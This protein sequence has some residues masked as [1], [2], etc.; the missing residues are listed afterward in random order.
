MSRAVI[1]VVSSNLP[2]HNQG[3][4]HHDISGPIYAMHHAI[5]IEELYSALIARFN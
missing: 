5:L 1:S 4:S 3:L 2:R